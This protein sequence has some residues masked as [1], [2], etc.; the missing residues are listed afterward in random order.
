MARRVILDTQYTFTPS[1]RTI[2]IPRIIPRERLLLIT[3]VTSNRVI[4]NFSDNTLPA[5]SYTYTQA[6]DNNTP[7]KTTIVLSYNTTSMNT[8]DQLQIVI[9]EA[10]ELFQPDEAFIDPVGKFRTSTPQALIDVD[11]E[12]GLQPTKW[13]TVSMINNRPAF[14]VNTQTPLGVNGVYGTN[15]SSQVYVSTTALQTAGTPFL[16]QDSFFAGGNGSFLMETVAAAGSSYVISAIAAGSYT[17]GQGVQAVVSVT[18]GSGFVAGAYVTIAGIT[19]ALAGYNTSATNPAYVLT[20]GTT[21]ITVLWP[22]QTASLGTSLAGSPT[23]QQSAYFT[24][25]ARYNFT[26]TTGN[27]YNS[28][29]TGV[30]SGQFYTGASYT[31]P[32]QP[33][34]SGTN[35][36]ITTTEPHGLQV[37]DG[38]YIAGA[39]AS[40]NAPNGSWTVQNVT[41][42]TA[43]SVQVTNA[44]TGTI[45]A[46]TVYP[47]PD[48]TYFHRAFDGGVQFTAQNPAHNQQVIR[49]TRRYFRYQSG[50]G[51]QIS[52]GTLMKPNINVDELSSSGTT[53]TVTC[54]QAHLINAGVNIT[55]SGANETAYNGTF[56]V[57]SVLDAFRFQYTALTTPSASPASGLPVFSITNWYG[58]KVRLGLFDNQNGMFF[59]FDGQT[60]YAVRRR[61]TDQLA[62]WVNVTNGSAVVSGQTVNSVTT[63]FSKQLVPGD[64]VVIRGMSYR[65]LD[66]ASDT[67][68]TISPPFRGAT[69]TFPAIV[70]ISKTVETKVPQSAFNIDKLDGTGPSGMVLDLSKMQ[71][72]Y[73]DYSWYG[74]G[75]LRFGFRDTQGKVIYV[76]RFV[77]NNQNTEAWM[78]SGN[79]PARYEVNT[80]SPVSQLTATANATQNYILVSNTSGF[81]SNGTVLIANPVSYEYVAYTGANTTAFTGLTRG[82]ATS[83]VSSFSTTTGS[84][85][86]TTTSSVSAV[87]PGMRVTGTGI[88]T[89]T[90]VYSI[91]TGA[92]STIILTQAATAS[93]SGSVALTFTQMGNPANSHTYSATA[94]IGIYL[95]A[96]QFAPTLSHWGTSV[97]MDG[98]F[99][100]DKSLQFTYGETA[101]TSVAAGNVTS[102]NTTLNSFNISVVNTVPL[103]VGTLV[104]G[105]GIPAGS[106]VSAVSAG[107]PNNTITLSAAATATGSTPLVYNGVSSL[108]SLR[109]S[110]SVDSGIPGTLGLKELVNRMQLTLVGMD[111]I[112][113]GNFLIQLYL[114]GVPVQ[115]TSAFTGYTLTTPLL[116]TY[117]RIAT[118]T[119]SLAQVADHN[120]PVY[121]SGGEA[122]YSFYAVNSAGS[123]NFS[124]TSADLTK[125]RDL[126]NSI[127]GGAANNTPGVGGTYPDG[128]DTLTIVA[129]NIGVAN[130]AIQGRLSWTEAQA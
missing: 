44:P 87:Q 50:K 128:P 20:G 78:R 70:T 61:S 82:Q 39:T 83:T 113:N 26:G 124:V 72:F 112:C 89:D 80:V 52:T 117:S 68:M 73:L 17:A 114:N 79:L 74:A 69:Q 88:P 53:V 85:T 21:S 130:A 27:L 30:F 127:L 45:A 42:S 46:A 98:Q 64:Y 43:F 99:D 94:P 108:M 101:T 36:S 7:P 126:G 63:K 67:S 34:Y 62:G 58:A 48:G 81:S 122:M 102:I 84:A 40:T 120:G 19:G 10:A 90:Y 110:P 55:V 32:S 92:T 51:I 8:T 129:T 104:S 41:N 93:A 56:T 121:T 11:F 16:M 23:I 38:I 106:T 96:P 59:E 5:T 103:F 118:G 97:I 65:V 71:M 66:I 13:E 4:Y 115:P 91:T 75:A 12:Y 119:S 37:G 33:V 54:K 57:S 1:T 2:V 24:Y 31:L 100:N 105:T 47:R 14:F 25:T 29:L 125:I 123:T 15:G 35:I 3:N 77:N 28:S 18:S 86:V 60:L 95:H 9:D 109:V 6:T 107:N 22:N 49:Q 111:V 116:G 76:H